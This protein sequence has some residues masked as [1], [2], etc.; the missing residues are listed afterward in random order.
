[1]SA[2]VTTDRPVRFGLVGFGA[3]GTHHARAIQ[4][5]P[6]AELAMIAANSTQSLTAAASA[7]PHIPV[8]GDY[9]QLL[10]NPDIDVVDIVVPT[11]LHTEIACAAL[12][13]KH[14]VL[15]EKPMASSEAD[16]HRIL[17]AADASQKLLAIGFELR[18]SRL[19]GRVHQLIQEGAIGTPQYCLI[20]LFRRPYRQGSAGWRYD[21][22]R[23]G[24]WILEEPIHFFDLACWYFS[25]LG[26][27]VAV[28]ARS[29]SRDPG[30]PLL[31]DNFTAILDFPGGAWAVISQTLAAFEH[32]QTVK[33]TGT[34]GSLWA[35]WSGVMD[36][37][38][39]PRF[40]LKQGSAATGESWQVDCGGPA[41]EVFEL[42]QQI[43]RMCA[44]VRGE[45]PLHADGL[46]GLK[47]VR[48]CLAAEQAALTPQQSYTLATPH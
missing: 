33:I 43:A 12:Q 26:E 29:S 15:L 20:E 42:Q 37:T 28:Q 13:H 19:W 45:Q 40:F 27:P 1:M 25:Q 21:R 10:A 36:R 7:Y 30:R 24:N 41:G 9:T 34:E 48:L 3:W 8:T 18:M 38:T 22:S 47:A 35:S 5:T 23:V 11:H 14:H 6:G 39:T 16:C 31:T 32:H 46:D 44:A 2:H 17:A 4:E